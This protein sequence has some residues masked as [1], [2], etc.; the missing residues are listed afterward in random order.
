MPSADTLRQIA[1]LARTVLK[2]VRLKENPQATRIIQEAQ[3]HLLSLVKDI[4]T[5][6][7]R[8]A[9]VELCL[10]GG[11]F[12]DGYFRETFVRKLR[13]EKIKVIIVKAKSF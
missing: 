13:R 1:W 8:K 2:K 7:G 11:L 12:R 4:V 6:L 5:Q 3:K 10:T 9:S